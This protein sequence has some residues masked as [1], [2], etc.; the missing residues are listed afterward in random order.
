MYPNKT[1]KWN[2]RGIVQKEHIMPVNPLPDI[3]FKPY[4]PNPTEAE[5]KKMA[6]IFLRSNE[7]RAADAAAALERRNSDPIKPNFRV[8][9]RVN[10]QRRLYTSYG[11]DFPR[12]KPYKGKN[13][14][15]EDDGVPFF[16]FCASMSLEQNASSDG[17]SGGKGGDTGGKSGNTSHDPNDDVRWGDDRLEDAAI[18]DRVK[19]EEIGVITKVK[20]KEAESLTKGGE[21]KFKPS[22]VNLPRLRWK[23]EYNDKEMITSLGQ[24][25]KRTGDPGKIVYVDLQL[26]VQE[27]LMVSRRFTRNVQVARALT[28]YRNLTVLVARGCGITSLKGLEMPNLR[29]CDLANN[30]ISVIED[31]EKFATVSK[32]I[33]NLNLVNNEVSV[34]PEFYS[35]V[36]YYTIINNYIII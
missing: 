8:N 10:E 28:P 2:H 27:V 15:I 33:E 5:V 14:G 12:N 4:P 17:K 24:L 11:I 13:G 26:D 21:A 31:V 19:S 34:N 20:G 18:E 9:E 25:A 22:Y 32:H 16:K 3:Q 36:N 6:R 7:Q 35:R 1:T 30:R 23:N 29:V